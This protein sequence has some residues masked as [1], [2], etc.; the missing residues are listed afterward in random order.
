MNSNER[1]DIHSVVRLNNNSSFNI[2]KERLAASLMFN[3]VWG[4]VSGEEQRP[5]AIPPWL[6][7]DQVQ[8]ME[9]LSHEDRTAVERYRKDERK[10]IEQNHVAVGLMMLALGDA[11]L[12]SGAFVDRH[13]M[14]AENWQSI[15]E[16]G[17]ALNA[18]IISRYYP[19]HEHTN[20]R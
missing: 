9:R 5:P 17:A 19:N 13:K 7:V 6:T 11:H 14:A 4:I 3:G 1:V 15:E 16:C 8:H 2:W 18:G 20:L 12:M 10:W